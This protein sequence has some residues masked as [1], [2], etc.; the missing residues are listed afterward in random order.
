MNA[1]WTS[2]QASNHHWEFEKR[3]R[4]HVLSLPQDVRRSIEQC[5]ARDPQAG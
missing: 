1:E 4:T 2:V 5:R 3:T